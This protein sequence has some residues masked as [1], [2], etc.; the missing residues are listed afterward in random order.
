MEGPVED[1]GPPG[2]REVR[3]GGA[4]I[5]TVPSHAGLHGV[6]GRGQGRGRILSF[7]IS[8][9]I[10]LVRLTSPWD[11]PGRRAKGNASPQSHHEFSLG[12]GVKYR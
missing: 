8:F 7:V 5:T 1:P 10:S 3:L 11:G 4:G 2:G 6:G 9:V 12:F